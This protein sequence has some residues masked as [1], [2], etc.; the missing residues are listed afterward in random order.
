MMGMRCIASASA[1][2]LAMAFGGCRQE[3][4]TWRAPLHDVIFLNDTLTWSNLV[5]D[6]LWSAGDEGLMLHASIRR[7][8]LGSADWLPSL[9]TAW[10]TNF[11]L[12]FIGGP[13][14]VAPGAEIWAEVEEVNLNLA[15]V[16][17]RRVRLGGG[18]L[19]LS[20]A[21]SVAGPLELRYEIGGATFPP[22]INGG[23]N[24]F[25]VLVEEGQSGSLT[26]PLQ[27]VEIDLDGPDG[28]EANRLATA[29]QVG[30]PATATEE[31][32][33]FG[34]DGLTL[35]V[36]FTGL[37]VAQVEGRF[38]E[39]TLAL[40][41]TLDVDVEAQ[42]DDLQI[43][44]TSVEAE[45][46][47][48]NT[49]GLD[50]QLGVDAMGRI[51]SA[52]IVT[53]LNDA[54]LGTTIFLPRATVV[55]DE[56]MADWSIQPASA[57]LNLGT[58]SSDLA[59]FLSTPP[60]AFTVEGSAMINPLG[61]VSGGYDRI[62]FGHLPELALTFKAPLQ[63]GPTAALWVDT[64]RPGVPDGIGFDGDLM[65]TVENGLPVEV[66]LEM[67]LVELPQQF[68][69][70]QSQGLPWATFE[71]VFIAAGNGDPD[72][73]AISA[74]SIPLQGIQFDALRLGAGLRLA[75]RLATAEPLAQFDVEQ[76]V[77]VIGHLEG[78]AIISIE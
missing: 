76:R 73:P 66:V 25:V 11:T 65:L 28:L 23:D 1:I 75:V 21:S 14:P 57:T 74:V 9:D 41:D 22:G 43:G 51:D 46:Q 56:G 32:G 60:D 47:F 45:L 26:V 31:V 62:D 42:L 30:V 49:T 71:P 64:I 69:L 27:G 78:D 39:R 19:Q 40:A 36:A 5:P 53:P 37:E 15:D 16:D 34:S 67:Q 54:A 58:G 50:V 18:T 63:V 52:G 12:P 13:I 29:W 44:W 20:V 24:T 59:G 48:L 68:L 55:E 8:L 77:V 10:T 61:D 4:I 7:P 33:L 6:T 70:L 72:A 35:E 38:G 2:V 3:P 17:L